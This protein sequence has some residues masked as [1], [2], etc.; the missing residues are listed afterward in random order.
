[1]LFNSLAFIFGFLPLTCAIWFVLRRRG[2]SSLALA[3]LL[4]ASLLFYSWWNPA[5][6]IILLISM[7]LNFGIGSTLSRSS[8]LPLLRVG[9]LI[10]GIGANLALLGYFKYANFLV[11]N[12]NYVLG[13]EFSLGTI[14]L[15][16]GISFFTFQQIAY[17]VDAYRGE[18][19]RPYRFIHYALFVAFFPQ[20]IAG[21][22]VH[23]KDLVQQFSDPERRQPQISQFAIGITI[24]AIGLFKKVV[25]ADG[26][27]VY[28]N[29]VFAEADAGT[30]L[31]FCEA[32]IGAI[33]YT[34]QLYFDFSG[35]SD[36][37]IGLAQ[38]VGIQLPL[39]FNSPY[40]ATSIIDFWNR[41][42]ITLSR[43]LRNYLYIPLGGNRKGEGRRSLNLMITML[44]AGLWHGAG[45]SFVIWGGMHGLYLVVN[46]QWRAWRRRNVHPDLPQSRL[47]RLWAGGLTFM[48]V[49]VAWVVFRAPHLSSAWI[50]L[51]GMA[52]INGISL[53]D[54]WL[55]TLGFL[56]AWGIQFTGLMPHIDIQLEGINTLE[57]DA[58]T[59]IKIL[60]LLLAWVWLAPNTQEWF[61]AHLGQTTQPQPQPSTPQH[62]SST[63]PMRL[64]RVRQALWKSLQWQPT[65]LWAVLSAVMTAIGLLSL[66]NVSQFLYFEF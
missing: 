28:A 12:L 39:N 24:F 47:E 52:G 56:R 49:V 55:D 60:L 37:A 58:M 36:M 6:L 29:A 10:T 3:W 17:L 19:E 2:H 64:Q 40:K 16:L 9:L 7:G 51:Q 23:H 22:I 20:L 1:M 35:Y 65:P 54:D 38:M 44:L 27:A 25:F 5:N 8:L 43:F 14:L 61:A 57:I 21:P 42:H 15:P 13:S 18:I 59:A 46:H 30:A 53:S 31:S 63:R 41:W 4:I 34:L 11:A 26:V 33:A 32:W 62:L 45:W 66:T 50:M 48:V